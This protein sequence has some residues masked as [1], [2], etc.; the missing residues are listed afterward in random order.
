MHEGH[1]YLFAKAEKDALCTYA[2][3][4]RKLLCFCS[5]NMLRVQRIRKVWACIYYRYR[6][7]NTEFR[8]TG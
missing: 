1:F 8:Q 7:Q 2:L 4:L 3:I 5:Q 6:V